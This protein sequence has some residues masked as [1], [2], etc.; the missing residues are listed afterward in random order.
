M[1]Q[2]ISLFTDES[3]VFYTYIDP[4]ESENFKVSVLSR[5]S[6]AAV[7]IVGNNQAISDFHLQINYFAT[8]RN[9]L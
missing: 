3:K 4:D 7:Y 2:P 8:Y 5:V 1:R 9:I 6:Y